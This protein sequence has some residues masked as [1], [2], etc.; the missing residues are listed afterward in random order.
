VLVAVAGLVVS[1]LRMSPVGVVGGRQLSVLQWNIA[2]ATTQDGDAHDPNNYGSTPVTERLA[3]LAATWHPSVIS[4]N[5]T[6]DSQVRALRGDLERRGLHV[7]AVA[8]SGT[9]AAP[10]SGPRPD[11]PD[12]ACLDAGGYY[13][14]VA[15]VSLV[16]ASDPA[17]LWFDDS[18][19]HV[20]FRRTGRAAACLTLHLGRDVR[21][22]TMHLAQHAP[23]AIAQAQEFVNTFRDDIAAHPYLL[24]GDFNATPAQLLGTMY[25]PSAGGA[26]PFYEAAMDALNRGRPTDGRRKLDYAFASSNAFDRTHMGLATLDPGTCRV[27]NVTEPPLGV[28]LPHPCSDHRPILAS[29]TLLTAAG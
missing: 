25:D 24:L 14:G 6:C 5:E 1:A 26:G 15:L 2:G 22:C 29:L 18:T 27:Y 16:P 12:P 4:V 11:R 13:A 20:V 8:F 19:N 21:A 28:R 17:S 9:T 10:G 3:A 23:A 7:Q